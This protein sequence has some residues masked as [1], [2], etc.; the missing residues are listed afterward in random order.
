MG[1]EA[2]RNQ[3]INIYDCYNLQY[4][5]II[6]CHYMEEIQIMTEKLT[7]YTC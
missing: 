6:R 5:S 2:T 4:K 7:L 1:A 3:I